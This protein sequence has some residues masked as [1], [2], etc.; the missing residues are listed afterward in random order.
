MH[1]INIGEVAVKGMYLAWEG[2]QSGLASD[3]KWAT[4]FP[5]NGD[6]EP[7]L[8]PPSHAKN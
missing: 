6:P 2:V 5:H 8:S 3:L 7:S 4:V 1:A